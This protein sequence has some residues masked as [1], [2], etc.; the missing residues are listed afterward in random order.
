MSLRGSAAVVGIAELAP[1]KTAPPADELDVMAGLV[2][3]A[4]AD[5]GLEHRDVDGLFAVPP[6]R[7]MFFPSL[8]SEHVG[9]HSS[10]SFFASL[11]NFF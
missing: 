1:S 8:L 10:W 5:A 2:A 9:S 6:R 3:D 11:F 7:T 4:L